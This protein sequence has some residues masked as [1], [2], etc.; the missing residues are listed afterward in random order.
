MPYSIPTTADELRDERL[1]AHELG[2]TV[3][4]YRA[5]RIAEA[6][7]PAPSRPAPASPAPVK[8]LD[9]HYIELGRRELARIRTIL[10]TRKAPQ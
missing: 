2:L 10:N 6:S 5:Q 7:T 1:A 8:P 3:N 9:P 4:E